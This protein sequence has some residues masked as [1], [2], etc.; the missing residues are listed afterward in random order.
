MFVDA[1]A[2]VAI[3]AD[4]PEALAFEGRL[5]EAALVLISPIV[6]WET[7]RAVARIIQ[8]EPGEAR[9]L[10]LGYMARIGARTVA[11][12]E[13]EQAEALDAH[14]RFG[15]SVHPARLNMGDCFA[16]ACARTHGVPLLF[17]GDDFSLT[18]IAPA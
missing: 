11:I 1:S 8:I 18:D 6:V 13:I 3:L 2:W 14:T 5:I 10:T 16:Y 9:Q 12:G 7:V 17:K 15:K 4:E